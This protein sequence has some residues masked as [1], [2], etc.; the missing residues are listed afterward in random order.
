MPQSRARL[1]E[2]QNNFDL[3]S[4]QAADAFATIGLLNQLSATTYTSSHGAEYPYNDF[5]MACNRWPNP[6]KADVGL[7]CI[8]I[9]GWGTH[10]TKA[11]PMD[12]WP[13]GLVSLPPYTGLFIHG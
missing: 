3:L 4:A 5:G 6:L 11:G 8:D 1:Y 9:S 13:V 12:R 10:K 7:A 2:I